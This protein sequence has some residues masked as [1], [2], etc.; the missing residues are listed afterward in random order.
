MPG[1]SAAVIESAPEALHYPDP[2]TG[3]ASHSARIFGIIPVFSLRYSVNVPY[4]HLPPF[5]EKKTALISKCSTSGLQ[6]EGFDE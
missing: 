3:K 1:G 5:L 4:V 2:A 6:S